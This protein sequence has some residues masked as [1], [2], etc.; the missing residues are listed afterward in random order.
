MGVKVRIAR[1]EKKK[2]DPDSQKGKR[3]VTGKKGKGKGTVYLDRFVSTRSS[4]SPPRS[5]GGKE[6]RQILRKAERPGHG[7]GADPKAG[8]NSL[9]PAKKL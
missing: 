8:K 7:G 9:E 6:R 1:R 2:R 4:M 5:G 3:K